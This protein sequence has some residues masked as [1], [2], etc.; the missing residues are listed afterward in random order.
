[1]PKI[2]KIGLAILVVV[3]LV[4]V[5]LWIR[6]RPAKDEAM[7]AGK[8]PADFPHAANDFFK[9]MDG[10]VAL[11][12]AQVKGRN[13]WLVWTAG[14]E[15]FWDYLA[16]QSFGS[17]D[18]LK[19][20]SSY[21]CSPQQEQELQAARA[22]R[23]GELPD[24]RLY[25]RSTRFKYLGLMNE[26]GFRQAD[27]PDEY[28]LCL[29]R[30]TRSAPDFDERIYGRATGV[31]GLRLYPNPNFVD[32]KDA[33]RIWHENR[34]KFYTD[35]DFYS[36]RTLVRPYRVGMSCAFC[37]VSHHP[38]HPPSDPENPEFR[39]LSATIGAQYFWF[40][41][42]FGPNLTPRSFV[43]HLLDSQQPGAL[44]TSFIPTDHINN[45]RAMNAIFNVAARLDAANRFHEETV[46]G[47]ALDL[48]QVQ[49]IKKDTN[50]TTFGTPQILWDGAD[51][52]GIDAALT[53]V[54]INIGE[55][56]E[57][58]IRHIQPIVGGKPQTPIKVSVA[59]ENS[60]FW[61]ATQERAADLADYLVAA[62]A[63]MHL[64]DAP[65]GE[66]HLRGNMPQAEYDVTLARGKTVFA[67]TCA[68]CHSSKLPEP[69]PGLQDKPPCRGPNYL[70]CWQRYWNW[71]ESEEFKARMRQIVM[72]PDFLENNY[73]S[74]DARIPVTQLETE[75][76]SA[77]ASNAIEGYVWDNF[78]SE[79]YKQLPAVG[80][81]KL[82]D[83]LTGE[84]R[85]WRT[86]G[87]GRGYQRVP[88]LV[89]IWATAPFLHNNE[90]G[91]G[92]LEG[93]HRYGG[94][95]SSSPPASG[96]YGAG[97][98]SGL[99]PGRESAAS[100]GSTSGGSYGGGYHAPTVSLDPSTAGRMHAFDD[101]IRK[102][103]WPEKRERIIRR[104]RPVATEEE[105]T[106]GTTWLNVYESSLPTLLQ[107]LVGD[108][109]IPRTL[110]TV[111]RLDHLAV[112]NGMLKI[113]PIPNGTPVNLLANLNVDRNDPRFSYRGLFRLV[114]ETKQRLNRIHT[115][116]LGPEQATALLKELAPRFNEMSACPDFIVDRGHNFGANLPDADKEALIAFIKTF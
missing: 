114:H 72:A 57:E 13:T 5:V 67:D 84:V 80:D 81:V 70:E 75:V 69:A 86:P 54:F 29:D 40:G 32:N 51:S 74:T 47:G 55:F 16:G 21:P 73:L 7:K 92:Y 19:T 103:L 26:P 14:N 37:H 36:A 31:L 58:W 53:R 45:P 77:M 62:S 108:G 56:H 99:D 20:L 98:A 8:T 100:A 110:R 96:P 18:L 39:N 107:R 50:S 71:T 41:R 78:S 1:M 11:T 30:T 115:E 10:G 44:D 87:G 65:D 113:G 52:V 63:P 22:K 79:T 59:Q 27:A 33:Q 109:L 42:I 43:W 85:S 24:Y 101:A 35:P 66:R 82:E 61:N 46:T 90:V 12:P 48:P 60:T 3:L 102:L 95:Y 105:K 76:C 15:A 25:S 4:A 23:P 49:Q 91:L 106:D 83:P 34:S 64:K 68:R 9:E 94:D 116:K 112:E 97:G 6:D 111:A 93:S 88:S 38:V 104:T 2:L 17:F 89:S 28:G